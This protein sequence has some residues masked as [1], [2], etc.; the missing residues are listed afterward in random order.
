MFKQLIIRNGHVIYC[1]CY[2][3]AQPL[4][5]LRGGLPRERRRHAEHLNL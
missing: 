2:T 3:C 4:P 5:G 1:A